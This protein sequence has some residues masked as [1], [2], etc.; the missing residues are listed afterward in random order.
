[1]ASC[2]L[3][4]QQS[5]ERRFISTGF[6][7]RAKIAIALGRGKERVNAK[8]VTALMMLGAGIGTKLK[9]RAE[10]S[11]AGEAVEAIQKLFEERFGEE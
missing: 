10:G 1:M 4:V 11:D 7:E 8:S 2:G 3:I 6:P 9:L 5:G